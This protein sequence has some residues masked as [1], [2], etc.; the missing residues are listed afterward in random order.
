MW[1]HIKMAHASSLN[2]NAKDDFSFEVVSSFKDPMSRQITE[3]T[4][5]QM[6]LGRGTLP[7]G[8]ESKIP[9]ISLNRK[10]ESFLQIKHFMTS[11]NIA[12]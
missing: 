7:K 11:D 12:D 10:N 3:A 2:F 1:D 9:V 8:R 6:A 5:I 4:M